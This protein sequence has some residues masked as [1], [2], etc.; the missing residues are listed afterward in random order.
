MSCGDAPDMQET[1]YLKA[2]Q[3]AER[4][5]FDGPAL[6]VYSRGTDRPLRFTRE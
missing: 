2:L 1:K 6:L 3:G 4:F 5:A